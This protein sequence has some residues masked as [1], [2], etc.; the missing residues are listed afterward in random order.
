MFDDDIGSPE[1]DALYFDDDIKMS[2]QMSNKH[3]NPFDYDVN[4]WDNPDLC[5]DY[6]FMDDDDYDDFDN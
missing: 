5:S 6:E 2:R 4:N 3:S 1:F